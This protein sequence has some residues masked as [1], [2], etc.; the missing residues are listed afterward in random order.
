MNVHLLRT[1]VVWTEDTEVTGSSDQSGHI[2]LFTV[3]AIRYENAEKGH[4][5]I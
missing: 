3:N 5:R 2:V 1:V 4:V